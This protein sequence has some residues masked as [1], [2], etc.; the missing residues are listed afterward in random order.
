MIVD[1]D[2]AADIETRRLAEPGIGSNSDGHDDKVCVDLPS[3]LQ[4]NAFD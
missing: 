3:I 1:L 2:T 4:P